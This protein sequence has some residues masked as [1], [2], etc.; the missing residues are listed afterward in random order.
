MSTM[1]RILTFAFLIAI[2]VVIL[3]TITGLPY[4]DEDKS[5][6]LDYSFSFGLQSCSLSWSQYIANC[7][8]CVL[9]MYS[10]FIPLSL[11]HKVGSC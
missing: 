6:C 2:A 5:S 7:G 1:S 3:A 8:L 4:V 10:Q 11:P 9:Y